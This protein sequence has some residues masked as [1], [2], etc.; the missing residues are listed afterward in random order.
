M[1]YMFVVITGE[2]VKLPFNYVAHYVGKYHMWKNE[3]I[4]V[5]VMMVSALFCF[6][7]VMITSEI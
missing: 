6:L 4:Y 7:T 5:A 2:N 1:L 3:V